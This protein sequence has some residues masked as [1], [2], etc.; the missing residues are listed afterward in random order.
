MWYSELLTSIPA[1]LLE[2]KSVYNALSTPRN[3]SPEEKEKLNRLSDVCLPAFITISKGS[4]FHKR[5]EGGAPG[6]WCW[7]CCATCALQTAAHLRP[8][9][10][11][12]GDD[13]RPHR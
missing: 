7:W 13:N 6:Y 8:A 1:S 2:I 4:N 12:G 10:R 5:R 9:L 11:H 3:L